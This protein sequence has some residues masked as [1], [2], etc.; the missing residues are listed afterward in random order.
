MA[1]EIRYNASVTL[2]KGSLNDAFNSSG[3]MANQTTQGLVRN[4][5]EVPASWVGQV[6]ETGSV[7]NPR[8]AMFQNLDTVNYVEVGLSISGDFV[9]FL[10]LEAGQQ[11]GPMWLAGNPIPYA[12]ANTSPV[13]LFYI[14]YEA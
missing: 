4:V 14:M 6:L 8:M 13:K 1:N 5:Q 7:V 11:A 12:R 3:L 10:K 9:A 2:S